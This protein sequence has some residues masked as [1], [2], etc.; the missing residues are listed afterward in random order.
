MQVP[1]FKQNSINLQYESD[2][3]KGIADFLTVVHI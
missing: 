2:F 3:N 1:F